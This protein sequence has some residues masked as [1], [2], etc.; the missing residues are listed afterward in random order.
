[1]VHL[2]PGHGLHGRYAAAVGGHGLEGGRRIDG[3]SPSALRTPFGSESLPALQAAHVRAFPE[4]YG[5]D[6]V[7]T[8]DALRHTRARPGGGLGA[9]HRLLCGGEETSALQIRVWSRASAL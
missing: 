5:A 1:M 9:G 8:Q 7:A 2:S 6:K 3:T 4:V